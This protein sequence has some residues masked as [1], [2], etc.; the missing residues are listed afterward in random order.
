MQDDSCI[1]QF[2][3]MLAVLRQKRVTLLIQII[4]IRLVLSYRVMFNANKI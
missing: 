1:V 2:R 4:E 3:L